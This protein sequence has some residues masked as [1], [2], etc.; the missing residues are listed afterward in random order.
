MLAVFVG[1]CFAILLFVPNPS[2]KPG[3]HLERTPPASGEW[4]IEE[5]RRFDGFALYWVGEEF[6]GFPLTVIRRLDDHEFLFSYGTCKP[7]RW[8]G[9]C[10]PPI[11]VRVS[12]YCGHMGPHLW[13][14]PQLFRGGAEISGVDPRGDVA[15]YVWAG[16]VTVR[17]SSYAPGGPLG[18]A[19]ALVALNAPEPSSPADALPPLDPDCS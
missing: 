13:P 11:Q 14:E 6:D 5:A 9:G 2:V 8:E 18:V 4:T 12:I 1:G 15:T 19:E 7:P 3:D 17:I 10:G 16:K